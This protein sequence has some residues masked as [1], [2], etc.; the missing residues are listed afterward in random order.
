MSIIKRKTGSED[1]VKSVLEF[2]EVPTEGSPN[3][4]ESGAVAKAIG[5]LGK[6]LQW[7]GPATVAELNAGITG[8]QEGWT[9][10]LTDAGTLTD[11]SVKVDVGDEVA[12]T[13][14]AWF[15]LGGEGGAKVYTV[16]YDSETTTWNYPTFTQI[17]ADIAAGKFPVLIVTNP[18]LSSEVYKLD[19]KTI[20]QNAGFYFSSFTYR[21]K[22]V[23]KISSDDS[24]TNSTVYDGG[25]FDGGALTDGA[26]VDVPN[27]SNSTLSSSQA[28]LTLRVYV[29]NG[30]VPN[31][32]VEI[33]AG[34]DITL[35]VVKTNYSTGVTTTL[36]YSAAAGNT[37]ENGKIY[38][39][40]CVGS[41]WTLAE[42][43]VPTP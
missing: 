12:W 33:T 39:V 22:K 18:A 1:I 15:K 43:T 2:D 40:T 7:K 8:I 30:E 23:L 20:G 17:S 27:N 11:G 32:A 29:Y 26:T 13:G 9:Y 14:S 31:F 28:A 24:I 21:T 5:N 25:I 34:T 10:T 35:T 37:L 36:N 16:T 4:V 42:F 38:Q 3:L 19:A 6:P 41:C